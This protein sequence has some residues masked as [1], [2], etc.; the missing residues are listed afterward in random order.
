MYGY[1][2]KI[3]QTVSETAYSV[4]EEIETKVKRLVSSGE[5]TSE[6][7]DQLSEDIRKHRIAYNG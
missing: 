1:A 6:E 3:V 7:G 2:R 5:I 4:E